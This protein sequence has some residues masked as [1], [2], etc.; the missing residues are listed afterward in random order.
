[1][2]FKLGLEMLAP[3]GEFLPAKLLL[4]VE[5][6]VDGILQKGKSMRKDTGQEITFQKADPSL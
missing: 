6:V 4:F 5:V 1:L 3:G 2:G